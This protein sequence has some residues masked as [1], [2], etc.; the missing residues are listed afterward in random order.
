[1]TKFVNVFELEAAFL[2]KPVLKGFP[3]CGP[4]LFPSTN[5]GS[6]LIHSPPHLLQ[7]FQRF[8]TFTISYFRA[9]G[10]PCQVSLG[11]KWYKTVNA[12]FEFER[13]NN[14]SI[15]EKQI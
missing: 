1:M 4:G 11:G 9:K 3:N 8:S 6:L 13:Q 5:I 10:T 7:P 2:T 12:K 14:A 15:L